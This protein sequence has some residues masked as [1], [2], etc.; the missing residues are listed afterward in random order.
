MK[1]PTNY[2]RVYFYITWFILGIVQ[3]YF[4]ELLNDE[5]YYWVYSKNLAW[6]YFDH[7]PFI[8]LCVKAGYAFLQNEI[9]VRIVSITLCTASI[10]I[11]EKIIQPR[12][13]LLFASIV[14]SMGLLHFIGF[15]AAP[16]SPLFFFASL[17]FYC[18]KKLYKNQ[19]IK[20]GVMIGIIIA[21][22]L[23][24]KYHGILL[25][26]FTILANPNVVLKKYFWSATLIAILVLVPHIVWLFQNN[27]EPI[28]YH[29][30]QRDTGPYSITYLFSYILG[31]LF[32]FGPF[33]GLIF[34][35]ACYHLVPKNLFERTLK[36]SALGILVFFLLQ[37]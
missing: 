35:L 17:Y 16:D 27:F 28:N 10:Y 22:M 19:S 25:V 33:V 3:A 13:Y 23:Y 11:I 21:L 37:V 24:S 36:F 2:V 6:G 8:A 7:P 30:F 32:I 5:A 15:I 34:Y 31:L 1:P 26:L 4:T 12:N 9:G 29:F 20:W 14:F 18:L